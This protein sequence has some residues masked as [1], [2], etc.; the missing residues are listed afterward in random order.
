MFTRLKTIH[1]H[2]IIVPALVVSIVLSWLLASRQPMLA[3]PLIAAF[4]VFLAYMLVLYNLEPAYMKAIA[5]LLP[6]STPLPFLEGSMIRLPTEPMIGLALIMLPIFLLK[7]RT[8]PY[9]PLWKEI[10]YVIPLFGVYLFSTF[11]SEM[12]VV[13]LKFS[14]VNIAYVLVFYVFLLHLF[15][16]DDCLFPDM[17]KLYG[18]GFLLVFLWSLYQYGQYDWNPLVLR[19]I[20]RPFYNDH[21]IF[22]ASAALLAVLAIGPGMR[23]RSVRGFIFS[24]VAGIFFLVAVFYSTS[25]GAMLSLVVAAFVAIIMWL[26]PRPLIV[27]TVFVLLLISGYALYP[28]LRDRIEKTDVLSYETGAGVV[29]RTRSVANVSTDVSNVERLN[30]WV[31]AWRMF[32]ERPL[33][34]FGPG[35]YQFVYIPYQ[36]ERLMN[37]LT[38]TDP[39]NPPE[40]SGGTAHSEYLLLL[41]ET[42]IMGLM[43]FLL[44][45]VRW[46][47]LAVRRWRD[48]PHRNAMAVALVALSTYFFHALVNNFLTTDKMAFLFWGTAAWLV[49]VYHRGGKVGVS[50]GVEGREGIRKMKNEE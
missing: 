42:G 32:R 33:T 19:G 17:L 24:G 44:I 9:I 16:K 23:R 46:S 34:G 12:F 35:T 47:R 31:S 4:S 10:L 18:M 1:P 6:F 14:L 13:S 41:S 39:Y 27:V 50:C 3:L 28:G 26:K 43:A 29:D 40:G 15:R 38:V 37:R 21:T 7:E 30:R 49:A 5:F 8:S 36:E 2:K 25:R 11:F 22:G 48:H 20:F 45:L